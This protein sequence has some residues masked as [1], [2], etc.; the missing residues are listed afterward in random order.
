MH[1]IEATYRE[2][3]NTVVP[4]LIS[5]VKYLIQNH[6]HFVPIPY[7]DLRSQHSR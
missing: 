4:L 3:Y 5:K 7:D 2:F 1:I 6:E